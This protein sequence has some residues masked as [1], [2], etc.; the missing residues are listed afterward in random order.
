M[1]SCV[2]PPIPDNTPAYEQVL[3]HCVSQIRDRDSCCVDGM[4][5][6]ASSIYNHHH[7]QVSLGFP[8]PMGADEVQYQLSR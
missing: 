8:A 6:Y 7:E 1:K 2:Y 4:D 5:E 3:V